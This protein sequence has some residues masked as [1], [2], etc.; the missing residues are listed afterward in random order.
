MIEADWSRKFINKSC[1]RIRLIFRYGIEND[2][3]N[4]PNVLLRLKALSPLLR[5]RTD[6]KD[7]PARSVVPQESIDA[8]KKV[9][10]QRTADLIDFQLLTGARPGELMM[11]TGA[12]I[13][14]SRE[15][16]VAE[17]SDHKNSHHGKHRFLVFGPRAQAILRRY[18][19][20]DPD[21]PLFT[22]TRKWYGMAVGFACEKVGVP[23]FTPHWL[24]HNAA[25]NLREQFGLDAAQLILGH[26]SA[27]VT[28]VYAHLNIKRAVEVAR[29]VG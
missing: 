26:S 28:E 2:L 18:L 14:Q 17:L 7:P 15:I 23:R 19:V 25:S 27:N 8:V 1:S 4:D 22:F 13:D 29:D 6:A 10:P 20:E 5:G 11:L 21:Q 12:M 3:I 24:R 9:V 16:W